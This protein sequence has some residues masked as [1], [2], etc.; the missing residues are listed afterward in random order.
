MSMSVYSCVCVCNNSNKSSKRYISHAPV[1]ENPAFAPSS[2][3][4]TATR[5]PHPGLNP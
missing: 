5:L 1:S 3:V 4:F 2:P